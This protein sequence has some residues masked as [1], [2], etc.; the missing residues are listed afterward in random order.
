MTMSSSDP[1]ETTMAPIRAAKSNAAF[2]VS[3]SSSN[4]ALHT[5]SSNDAAP[6]P[7]EAHAPIAHYTSNVEIPDEI[8]DRMPRHRKL[9]IVVLLSFCS[10]LAPMSSTAVLSAVPEVAL[11]YEST[12]AVINISNALYMATMG[13]SPCFWGPLSQVYGRRWVRTPF[14]LRG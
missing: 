6:T 13:I 14:R 4:G 9:V 2:S 3:P 5:L 11:E 12:G 7:Q 8:Y 10:F 1:P